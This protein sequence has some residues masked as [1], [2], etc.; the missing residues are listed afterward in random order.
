M[1]EKIVRY[2]TVIEDSA[3]WDGFEFRPGDIVI[4]SPS[5]SG[6]TWTQMICALL[7]FQTPELP[8]PLTRLSPWMDMCV[9]PVEEVRAHLEAQT[10]RRFV[11]THT[12]LDGVPSDPRVTYLAV[13][14]D[15]R[16]VAISLFHQGKNLDRE[17]VRVLTGEPARKD[18]TT[19]EG[20]P[21]T[22]RE[23]F[24]RWVDNE[25]DPH[26]NLD[27]LYGLVWQQQRAWD[28]R[29]ESNVALVHYADLKRDLK[30]Q[31]RRL[32]ELLEIDVAA[33][34]LPGLAEAATFGRM[35]K[36][37]AD[38][39]PDEGLGLFKNT[40]KFFRRGAGKLWRAWMT[41]DD[42]ARYAARLEE[43]AAPELAHWL[44]HGAEV[45]S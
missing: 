21:K 7:I 20:P 41:D 22:E 16:D 28:R 44:H 13:G 9:R 3:R 45:A 14:R 38:Y 42:A 34:T 35:R 37:S 33:S 8:E 18:E 24:L 23:G 12:P 31:M 25:D 40:D 19:P 5:K 43:L 6:T 2:R 36:R 29:D 26:E 11:K 4:S 1:S 10:H 39:A 17:R 32:A 27:T 15:P 30:G